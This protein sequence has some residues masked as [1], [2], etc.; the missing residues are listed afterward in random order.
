MHF[1]LARVFSCSSERKA[2]TSLSSVEPS[3][4]PKSN[5]SVITKGCELL[6]PTIR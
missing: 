2:F 4:L 5:T 1:L 6:Q 3:E